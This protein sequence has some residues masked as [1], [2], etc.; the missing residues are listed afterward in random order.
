MIME[1]NNI[2]KSDL[3][4]IIFDHRNKEYGAYQLRKSYNLRLLLALTGTVA[5]TGAMFGANYI[6]QH[7]TVTVKKPVA[8]VIDVQLEA[9]KEEKKTE[10]LPPPPPPPPQAA[11]QKV[12]MTK[13]TAPKIVKDNEVKDNEKPPELEKLEETKIGAITRKG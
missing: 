6:A 7:T 8:S 11:I 9:I 13:F 1:P 5:I 10:P 3:L 4:D 12:E 2:L